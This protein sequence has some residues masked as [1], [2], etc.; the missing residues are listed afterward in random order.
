MSS[1]QF[2]VFSPRAQDGVHLKLPAKAIESV[3]SMG[4]FSILYGHCNFISV[5]FEKIT[6]W[7][8]S[9]DKQ[10]VFFEQAVLRVLDNKVELFAEV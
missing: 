7:T 4:P 5:V 10:E 3:N 6:C 2:T 8:E 9:G 1:F